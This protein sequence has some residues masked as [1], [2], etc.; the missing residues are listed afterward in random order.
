E[1]D[2]RPDLLGLC[3]RSEVPGGPRPSRQRRLLPAG[4]GGSTARHGRELH[5]PGSRRRRLGDTDPARRRH[6]QGPRACAPGGGACRHQ[7]HDVPRGLR[8]SRP[9][10]RRLLL[11]PRDP[12]RRLRRPRRKRWARR[13]ADAWSEHRERPDRGGRAQL[14]GAHPA[15]RADPGLRGRGRVPGRTGPP[16]GL[17]LSTAAGNLHDSG[18]PRS[19]RSVG[20]LRR[21]ARPRRRVRPQP[22]WR[23]GPAALQGD[24][25]RGPRRRSQLPHVRRRRVRPP[26]RTRS[27]PSAPGRGGR[28]GQPLE[29]AR[30]LRRGDRLSHHAG[31]HCWNRPPALW[32]SRRVSHYRLGVD[33]GGTF[34]D[35]SLIDEITGEGWSAKVPSPPAHPAP[36]FMTGA[37]GALGA[38]GAHASDVRYVVHGTTVATNA[39]IEGRVARSAFVTTEGF[40]DMLEIAR[41]VRPTLYDVR[42]E[43]P[44]PLVPRQLCFE[45][46]ERL[47][48]AC[49]VLKPLDERAVLL[50]AAEL[51][52]CQVESVAVCLLHSYLNPAHE[53]R[54]GELLR[55]CLPGVS[56]S[57]SSEVA[58]EIRE[59]L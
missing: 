4:Q 33:I 56:V 21:G 39:I 34:T 11:L 17:L 2:L 44:R 3:L 54:V 42:F 27:R 46:S 59:Y 19:G 38:A 43:K 41:Q 36:G 25:G 14:P 51:N 28:Q 8:R 20:T 31:G 58:P 15:A 35:A 50:L 13:R 32:V 10:D 48:A 55:A 7:S 53:K 5:G 40:R 57:L 6:L 47:D 52:T 16:Q 49:Q 24:A 12:G 26:A 23:R 30:G 29:S 9:G 37:E 22:G 45:V 18:R 1:L